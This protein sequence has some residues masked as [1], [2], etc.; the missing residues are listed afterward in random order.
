MD[1]RIRQHAEL[2]A[3][4]SVEIQSGDAVI[5]DAHPVAQDLV[6]ALYEAI[7]ARGAHPLRI[8][9][10]TDKAARRAYLRAHDGELS[11]APHELD[12]LKA[13]DVYIT[14]KGALNATELGDVD[15]EVQSAY[16]VAH[17]PIR[18]ERID[19]TRWVLTQFPA[20]AEAQLAEMATPQYENFVWDAV[21]KDWNAQAER[22]AVMADRLDE[23][24][25]VHIRSGEETD[26][27][28]SVAGN[29]TRNDHARR[30]L[31]GGE[32]FTAPIPDSVEGTVVFDKP[33]MHQGREVL[34][35]RLVFEGGE[36][37]ACEAAKNE[38]VLRNVVD[39]DPGARRLGELGIGMNRDIDRFTYNMLFDEKMGD[40]IHLALGRAYEDNI[41]AGNERNESAVHVDM[42][43]DMSEDS[44]I[45]LDGEIVQR[46][47]RFFFEDEF[48]G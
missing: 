36:V 47:G 13:T 43:V 8:T 10:R 11:T 35:G 42:I 16:T 14:I 7:G 44:S 34:D 32:V 2:I 48:A 40:T 25:E 31:P 4:H 17:G 22:Q 46:D 37:V 28:M 27:R 20:P 9:S 24:D 45:S 38:D 41:G 18:G 15:P 6:H 29:R 1:P 5:I 3:D 21:T 12:L 39:S 26:I 30:N 23:A 19:N 33:L